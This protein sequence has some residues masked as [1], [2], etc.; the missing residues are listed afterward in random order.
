MMII[1]CFVRQWNK[2]YF[3]STDDAIINIYW[4]F[5]GSTVIWA[6]VDEAQKSSI[7][8]RA[9]IIKSAS[10]SPHETAS[11]LETY[12]YSKALAASTS[13]NEET[14]NFEATLVST[15]NKRLNCSLATMS[16]GNCTRML[17]IIQICT[18]KIP[19]SFNFTV[20]FLPSVEHVDRTSD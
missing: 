7:N 14:D 13:C 10:A 20:L 15:S 6:R 8:F 17:W 19:H 1:C 11:V 9:I 4:F 2:F 5:N 16:F 18:R 3:H 12:H